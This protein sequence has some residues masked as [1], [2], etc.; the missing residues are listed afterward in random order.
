MLNSQELQKVVAK[1][2]QEIKGL[3][4]K[5]NATVL[6]DEEEANALLAGAPIKPRT[7]ATVG[8]YDVALQRVANRLQAEQ[9]TYNKQVEEETKDTYRKRNTELQKETAGLEKRFL[10]ARKELASAQKAIYTHND[11]LNEGRRGVP[12]LKDYDN[13]T[14]LPGLIDTAILIRNEDIKEGEAFRQ[15]FVGRRV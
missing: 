15:S 3:L 9:A 6:L 1:T 14:G 12:D 8:A 13:H 10:D 2:E 5:R 7:G 11:Q 4:A